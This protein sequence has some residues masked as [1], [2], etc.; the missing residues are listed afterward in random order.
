MVAPSLSTSSCKHANTC[1]CD[2][3][4]VGFWGEQDGVCDACVWLHHHS[5]L[6]LVSERI[7]VQ[8]TFVCVCVGCW[9]GRAKWGASVSCRPLWYTSHISP[10]SPARAIFSN[11]VLLC[12]AQFSKSCTT[13]FRYA[14]SCCAYRSSVRFHLRGGGGLGGKYIC[15]LTSRW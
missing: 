8:G 9:L 11:S 1:S 7:R 12:F 5:P 10:L 4:V 6:T 2:V 14:W 3:C 15:R 13:S